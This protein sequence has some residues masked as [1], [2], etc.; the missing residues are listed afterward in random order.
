MNKPFNIQDHA[1]LKVCYTLDYPISD[2]VKH[3]IQEFV[4]E[5]I[6]RVNQRHQWDEAAWL[7]EIDKIQGSPLTIGQ[8][9]ESLELVELK[10][11]VGE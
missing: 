2:P 11:A 4:C 10:K 3:Q 5:T 9:L 6:C 8:W 7:E 1:H